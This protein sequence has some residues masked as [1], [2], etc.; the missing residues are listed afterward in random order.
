MH[1][2]AFV[3]LTYGSLHLKINA[4][5]SL[6]VTLYYNARDDSEPAPYT[7]FVMYIIMKLIIA[8][9]ECILS[10][11]WLGFFQLFLCAKQRIGDCIS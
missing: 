5:M 9:G 10:L 2:D 3:L 7:V 8:L 6:T 1:Q 11:D 4:L